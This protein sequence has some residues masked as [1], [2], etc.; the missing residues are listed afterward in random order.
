MVID[1]SVDTDT[2]SADALSSRSCVRPPLHRPL[3]VTLCV[4]QVLRGVF[5]PSL[6]TI[7]YINTN[8]NSIECLTL[9]VIEEAACITFITNLHLL[10]L[11]VNHT[12]SIYYPY[13]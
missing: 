10:L 9:A 13:Q 3:G 8:I 11:I 4:A 7:I 5:P 1:H 2:R 12:S 6:S